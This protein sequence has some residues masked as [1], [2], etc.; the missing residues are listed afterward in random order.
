MNKIIHGDSL[1]VLKTLPS[2]SVDCVMTSPPYWALR[3]YGC[4]S[5]S[6]K[7]SSEDI[8]STLAGGGNVKLGRGTPNPNCQ[9]CKGTGRIIG[10]ENQLGLEP[11]FNEYIKKLCDIFDEV[12]RVLKKTGTCWINLGDSY[13][14]SCGGRNGDV[15]PGHSES[16]N[17]NNRGTMTEIIK[18]TKNDSKQ[19]N[20]SFSTRK[21]Y[22]CECGK[23]YD[24]L[25][26]QYFC[27]ASCSGKDNTPRI[28]KGILENKSLCNIPARFSIEMQNR[29]WI[30]R[31]VIIWH[32]PSCMP[33][34]VKDRFTVDF[35]YVFFF[36]KNRKYWFET[37]REPHKSIVEF[38]N[39]DI[40]K[41]AMND[42]NKQ[43]SKH[44]HGPQDYHP[45]GRNKRTVW[46]INPQPF[47]ESHF[48]CYPEELCK[49]PIK[50]GCPKGGIVLDPFCG[51]GTTCLVAKKL[52]R[53]YIGIELNPEYVKLANERINGF[54]RA[55]WKAKR[56]C[57]SLKEVIL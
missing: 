57:K 34:S 32:K 27:G 33:S 17:K 45:D 46:S 39:R 20:I 50:A 31:N 5:C 52:G 22:C 47:S 14:G 4:C 38:H 12:K 36:V 56:E 13:S 8:T 49:T 41:R 15:T 44:N 48:A 10:V 6:T 23:R 53:N 21:R 54:Q 55:D 51:S 19:L 25:P 28:N 35:E 40:L 1:T 30:L 11:T 37:Q 29:G 9:L 3:D 26:Y 43:Y 42:S 7:L 24:A 18:K 16:L 2:E